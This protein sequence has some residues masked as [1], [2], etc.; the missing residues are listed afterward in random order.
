M[1]ADPGFGY[2]DIEEDEPTSSG[3]TT[4]VDPKLLKA[5][6]A[7]IEAARLHIDS[8]ECK[9]CKQALADYDEASGGRGWAG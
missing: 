9:V 6:K 3:S 8:G 5:T 4:S 2:G 1:D 7:L